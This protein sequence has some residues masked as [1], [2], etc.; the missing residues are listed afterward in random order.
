MKKNIILLFLTLT[1]YLAAS[2]QISPIFIKDD[3]A[4]RGYDPVAYFTENKP[5]EGKP[6]FVYTWGSA[7][8]YF[9]SQQN[10]DSFKV[11][12][13]RY[14]PQYGGYCAYGLSEGHKA[15]TSVDAWKI[16]NGK[17]YLNYNIK[18]RELWSKNREERIETANKNWPDLKDKE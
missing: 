5:V 2:A 10:L 17:L 3:K 11:N 14:A 7:N 15:P 4:I 12:P 18:V 1:I 9:S 6:E 8:W 16:V 13:E